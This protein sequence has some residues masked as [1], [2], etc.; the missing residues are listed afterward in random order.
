MVIVMSTF[1]L[2]IFYNRF[3]YGHWSNPVFWAFAYIRGL[4]LLGFESFIILLNTNNG[5]RNQYAKHLLYCTYGVM[6]ILAIMPL[7]LVQAQRKY[8]ITLSIQRSK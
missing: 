4:V 3:L 2:L 6:T 8:H 1:F 7:I 5:F